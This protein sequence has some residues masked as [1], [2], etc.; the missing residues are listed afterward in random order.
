MDLAFFSATDTGRHR[1]NNEDAVIVDAAAGI[2]VLA[3][4]M[5]GYRAGEVASSMATSIVASEL[6]ARL[7]ELPDAADEGLLRMAV[8]DSVNAANRAIYAASAADPRCAGMAT[9]IVVAVFYSDGLLLA[10]AGDSRAYRWRAGRLERISR[11]HSL[12][13]EQ[14]DAGLISASDAAGSAHKNLVTRA[15]GIDPDVEL[16]MH[17]HPLAEG[18]LFLLCSD[19]LTDM[20]ADE[21]LQQLLDAGGSLDTL[22]SSLVDAANAAGGHDNIAV[23]LVRVSGRAAARP[24]R[25]NTR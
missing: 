5:G 16:E 11:D 23:I 21:Q 24:W 20:L 19:G 9:T 4:G 10:H 3:D 1:S 8:G 18:D 2:A 12:L 7:P 15:V 13:Q 22:G 25:P 17:S 6:A 14:L